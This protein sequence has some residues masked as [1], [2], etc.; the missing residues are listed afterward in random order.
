MSV[1]GV[2][3]GFSYGLCA[4]EAHV[5]SLSPVAAN[6]ARIVCRQDSCC[7]EHYHCKKSDSATN[8]RHPVPIMENATPTVTCT[9]PVSAPEGPLDAE[10]A[11]VAERKGKARQEKRGDCPRSSNSKA[12]PPIG[13]SGKVHHHYLRALLAS[14]KM[15]RAKSDAIVSNKVQLSVYRSRNARDL[16]ASTICWDPPTRSTTTCLAALAFIR[17]CACSATST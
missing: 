5:E 14:G 16:I 10:T 9:S 13:I 17:V 2:G 15:I 8:F 12:T 3:T 11:D 1:G 7:C 6:V 4:G